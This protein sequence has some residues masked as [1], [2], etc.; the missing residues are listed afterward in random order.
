LRTLVSSQSRRLPSCIDPKMMA[1]LA[2]MPDMMLNVCRCGRGNV[3]VSLFGC[4][5][6]FLLAW[7][8]VKGQIFAV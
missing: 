8:G 6:P 4:K 7:R 3:L 2:T 1:R 5:V